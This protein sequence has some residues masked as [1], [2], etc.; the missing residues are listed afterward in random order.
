MTS[1]SVSVKCSGRCGLLQLTA[2]CNQTGVFEMVTRLKIKQGNG[3]DGTNVWLVTLKGVF[4]D[5][6]H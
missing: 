2:Y 6:H 1:N 5:T 4:Q 3:V